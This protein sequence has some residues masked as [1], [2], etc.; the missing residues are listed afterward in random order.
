MTQ[1]A[2]N[3][4]FMF[5]QKEISLLAG[6]LKMKLKNTLKRTSLLSL[7]YA[8]CPSHVFVIWVLAMIV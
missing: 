6:I 3:F 4:D 8:F 7:F 5:C 1:L 2:S